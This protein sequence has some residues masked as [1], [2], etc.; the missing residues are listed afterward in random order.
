MSA[1]VQRIGET[2]GLERVGLEAIAFLL[3]SS[4]S[5]FW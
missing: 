3:A 5:G 1:F 4:C 2:K